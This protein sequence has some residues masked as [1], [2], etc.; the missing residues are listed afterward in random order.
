M[1]DLL[2]QLQRL[3]PLA[4]QATPSPWHVVYD[5]TEEFEHYLLT[6][7]PGDWRDGNGIANDLAG[8]NTADDAHFIAAAHNLLT[9][10]NLTL[11]VDALAPQW[12]YIGEGLPKTEG[13]YLVVG[14]GWDKPI[15][16]TADFTS[17]GWHSDSEGVDRLIPEGIITHWMPLPKAPN[18]KQYSN[19]NQ[20]ATK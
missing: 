5:A 13:E 20:T 8:I 11:L 3:A 17:G 14:T 12:V 4:A 18:T 19:K 15:V 6:L 9:P 16:S 2:Q 7:Q 10:E 1:K